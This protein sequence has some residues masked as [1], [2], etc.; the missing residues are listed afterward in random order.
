[1]YDDYTNSCN[2]LLDQPKL[3]SLKIWRMRT[4]ALETFK[5]VNKSSPE[6]IQ[7]II[8][9]KEI[10]SLPPDFSGVRV[11]RSLVLWIIICPFVLFSFGHCVVCSSS[12]YGFWLPR[13][14]LRTLL[15]YRK[16]VHVPRPRTTRY[17][18]KK[19][20]NQTMQG[21][22]QLLGS[23]KCLSLPGISLKIVINCSSCKQWP[24]LLLQ[25]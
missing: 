6:F 15:R 13:W 12:I 4:I 24:G 17:G 20:F 5:I 23:S 1:M 9:I 21:V 10:L 22:F 11:T 16:T 19:R 8:T 14:Y 2:F 25:K 3:P 18:K 7:N